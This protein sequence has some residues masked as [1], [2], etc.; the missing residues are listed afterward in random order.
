LRRLAD[1]LLDNAFKYTPS[2]GSVKL[3]LTQTE[4][5]AVISVQDSGVGIAQ[6]ERGKIFDRFYRLDKSRNRLQGGAGL[7]LAIAKW[8]VSQHHGSILVESNPGE[9]ATFRVELPKAAT[10]VETPLQA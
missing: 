8:I 7:G 4:E 10:P 1:I 5:N 9:G 6:E 2:P 3:V